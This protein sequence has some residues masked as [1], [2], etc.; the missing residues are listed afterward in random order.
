V[1]DCVIN[2]MGWATAV[3]AIEPA[4]TPVSSTTMSLDVFVQG[5]RRGDAAPMSQAAS[6]RTAR[7]HAALIL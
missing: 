4:A 2:L 5:F 6:A 1:A 3:V 7:F